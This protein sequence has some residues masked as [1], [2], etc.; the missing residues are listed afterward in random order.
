[1][2]I[3]VDVVSSEGEIFSGT[4]QMVVAPASE[5]EVGIYGGHSP[6][7]TRLIPG[8][9]RVYVSESEVQYFYVSGGYLEVQPHLVTVLSDNAL[10]A[11]DLDEAAIQKAKAAAEEAMRNKSSDMDWTIVEARLIESI[12]QLRTID[13]FRSSSKH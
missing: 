5:G 7:L 10:R 13:H 11:A 9:V 1:M 3:Q 6:L 12:A 2:A 4:A 8:S